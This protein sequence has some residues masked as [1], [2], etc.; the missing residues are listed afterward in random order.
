MLYLL[1]C[2][3]NVIYL[4]QFSHQNTPYTVFDIHGGHEGIKFAVYNKII[5]SH[6]YPACQLAQAIPSFPYC[7]GWA[8]DE[9][10]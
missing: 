10:I 9:D 7:R 1:L 4:L 6:H 3:P 5:L 8:G 2:L